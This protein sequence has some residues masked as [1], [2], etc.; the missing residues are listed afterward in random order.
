MHNCMT[1]TVEVTKSGGEELMIL[2]WKH[3]G[4][5]AQHDYWSGL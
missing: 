5:H 4:E 3:E 2:F 1:A